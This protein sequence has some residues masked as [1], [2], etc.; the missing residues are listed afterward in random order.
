[1]PCF[2]CKFREETYFLIVVFSFY[3]PQKA[4]IQKGAKYLPGGN[5]SVHHKYLGLILPLWTDI[6]FP[7]SSFA[8][9][10][11]PNAFRPNRPYQNMPHSQAIAVVF[12]PK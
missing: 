3:H 8:R 5:K 12:W 4:T 6:P 9:K 11:S 7:D 1:M 2:Y 10:K